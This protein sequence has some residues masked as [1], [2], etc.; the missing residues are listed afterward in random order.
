MQYFV[1]K[2]HDR[3]NRRRFAPEMVSNRLCLNPSYPVTLGAG[4]SRL[5]VMLDSGAFQDLQ[6][7]ERLSY[8]GALDRQLN[9]EDKQDFFANYLVSYDRIVD[10]SPTIQGV[11]KKRRVDEQT[12]DRYV[13]ETI[14]AAKFL[15]DQREDLAPRRLILSNQGVSPDQ[16]IDCI[17][18]V[19]RFA[20]PSDVIGLGGFCIIGQV[21]R[22]VPDYFEVLQRAIPLIKK[23]RIRRV[24]IFGVGVFKLLVKTHVMCSQAGIV[25]SYDTS[26]LELNAVF[27]RTLQPDI[28]NIGP[29]GVHLTNVFSKEDKYRLYHPCDWALLNIKVVN[30]FWKELNKLY[31]L[32]EIDDGLGSSALTRSASQRPEGVRAGGAVPT[33]VTG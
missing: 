2:N 31:P 21:P 4:A 14:N 26:S 19:L 6:T 25:P 17:K 12:A 1:S 16:Y 11:R 18:E 15:A 23:K 22:F 33:D 24:H 5:S 9:F 29:A 8:Q 3:L 13:E 20:E 30:Q 7:H 32:P 10:E 27:G 28:H